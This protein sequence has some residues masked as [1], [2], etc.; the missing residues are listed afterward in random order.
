[1]ANDPMQL[2]PGEAGVFQYVGEQIPAQLLVT[3]LSQNQEADFYVT[4]GCS[5]TR[6]AEGGWSFYGTMRAGETM[7]VWFE[8]PTA[9]ATI[10]NRGDFGTSIEIGGNGI[11]RHQ[12]QQAGAAY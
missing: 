11:F 8:W 6:P 12:E 3:N 10:V 9:F 2:G 1:M 5:S 7:S 4:S